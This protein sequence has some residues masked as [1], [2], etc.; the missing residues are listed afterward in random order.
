MMRTTILDNLEVVL[1]FL[2]L[3]DKHN[4][5]TLS[6]N[7]IFMSDEEY[8]SSE[9]AAVLEELTQGKLLQAQVV[10]RNEDGI[11]YCHIYQIN[12][13]KVYILDNLEVVLGFLTLKDKHN[14]CTL[15]E[16]IIFMCTPCGTGQ[17]NSPKTRFSTCF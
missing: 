2:T 9:A 12:G 13:D 7:I 16:N 15:S 8:F 10:G 3:K 14:I 4:I 6:E 11:A 17:K 5:C 1:G